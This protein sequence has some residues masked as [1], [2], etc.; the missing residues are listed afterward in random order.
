M[1]PFLTAISLSFVA[2]VTASAGL[3][4]PGSPYVVTGGVVEGQ[5]EN[6]HAKAAGNGDHWLEAPTNAVVPPGVTFENATGAGNLFMQVQPDNGPEAVPFSGAGAGPTIDYFVQFTVPG[7]Y[8][9][10]LRWDGH[11]GS[12]D[13][14]YAGIATDAAATNLLDWFED[15]NHVTSDFGQQGWD[16]S[17]QSQVNVATPA[18]NAMTF[19]ISGSGIYT[20]RVVAREDGVAL[21]SFRIQLASM[22]DPNPVAVT[23]QNVVFGQ[24][25]FDYTNGAIAG[26]T[27]GTYW[28]FDNTT[29][30]NALIGYTHQAPSTWDAVFGTPTITGNAL[31]TQDSAAKREHNASEV[32]G[33][34][35][36]LGS[37][38][39]Q[40]AYYR[41]KMTR[42]A[43]ATWGGLSVYD[44]GAERIFFGVQDAVNPSSGVREFI[45]G[46]SGV[47]YTGVPAVDGQTY[48]IVAKLDFLNDRLSMWI[49]PDLTQPEGPPN[50]IRS[51][52]GDNWMSAVRLGSGGGGATTWD[53]VAVGSSW[54]AMQKAY[55]QNLPASGPNQI[56][57]REEFNYDNGNILN[58]DNGIGWDFD[59][60]NDGGAGFVGRTQ[61]VSNWDNVEGFPY[62]FSKRLA[63]WNSSA[64][65][66]YNATEANGSFSNAATSEYKTLYYR[67]E[68]QRSADN[69]T[70]SGLS[71][72]DGG[73][74]LL[75]FGVPFAL[76]PSSSRRELGIHNLGANQWNYTGTA[77][78]AGTKYQIIAKVDYATGMASLYVN[79]SLTGS[80]PVVPN[81]TIA[82]TNAHSAIRFGSGG[83][84]PTYWD[85]FT[86]ATS[87]SAVISITYPATTPASGSDLVIGT[88]TFTYANGPV[89][90]RNGGAH[91]D[92]QNT[93]G[94]AYTQE[95]SA[96]SHQY[97][98]PYIASGKLRTW[99]SGAVRTFNGVEADG[100]INDAGASAFKAVY[101]RF[102]MQRDAGV[103]WG[104]MSM[105]DFGTERFL[106]GVPFATNPVSG[107]REFAI[108][109]LAS[110]ITY[111]GISP[112]AG[113]NYTLVAKLDF[114]TNKLVLWVNPNLTKPETDPQNTPAA[115]R[116]Y[117]GSNWIT[118]VRLASSA[119]GDTQWENLAVGTSWRSIQSA[120]GPPTA[121][122]DTITMRPN[123][124]VLLDVFR[125][126]AGAGTIQIVT[127][128]A[129]GT[130]SIDSSGR[131][132]YTHT[133]GSPTSDSLTY[134]IIGLDGQISA[135]V[136]VTFNFSNALRIA[137]QTSVVPLTPPAT[138]LAVVDSTPGISFTAP[139]CMAA[140][141]G[142]TNKVLVGQRNGQIWL[143]N[144]IHSAAPTRTLFMTL[145]VYDDGNE[146]G[147]K[148]LA[149]H[150]NFAT[151]RQ[152]FVTYNL[153]I[154][155]ADYAR[156]SRF[157]AVNGNLDL[158]DLASEQPFISIANPSSIH[159]IDSCRFGPDGYFYWAAGDAGNLNDGNNNAQRIDKDFWAGIFRIDVDRRP[160]NIEPNAHASIVLNGSTAYYKVPATNP[161]IGA[162]SFNGLP[163]PGPG[164]VR[165]EIFAIGMRNPWQFSFDPQNGEMW[166]GE[167]GLD[168]WEE[169]NVIT[170]G[171]NF[172]WSYLE[173]A[174]AG[175]KTNPPVGFAPI[176]PLWT[177]YHGGGQLE[178]KSVTGG[179]V[180]R[181]TRYP[182]L[183]GKYILGDFISGHIWSL[184]RNGANP[185]TVERVTGEAG[186]VAFMLDPDPATGD[187]LMLDYG[188][189]KVR[190]LITQTVDT[191]FPAKLSDTGLFADLSDLSLNPGIERYDI[192]LPFWSDYARKSRWFML[193]NN[194]DTF[195]YVQ[196][197][198]WNLPTG[199]LWIKHFD[200]DQTR[201]NPVTAK[202]LET[203]LLVKNAT[204][205]YGVSY[206]WNETGT[207]AY[208]V[209]DG[210]DDFDMNVVINS[211]PTNV[212]WRIP[213]RSEC[214]AC[215]TPA[216][217]H[218]LSFET[219]QLNRTGT[220][221]G[222]TGNY[223][224]LLANA[225]Y[226]SS[227]P[228]Q[229]L[230]L[231]K[232]ATPIDTSHSLETRA[233]SWLA[234]NCSYCHQS[235]GTGVGNF[236]L[237]PEL[238]LTQSGM[239]DALVG[240]VQASDHR[241]VVRG[242][243]D[244]SVIWNRLSASGGYTRMP[245]LATAVVDPEGVQ[246]VM[247]WINSSGGRQNYT[248][249]RLAQFGSSSSPPGDPAADADGDGVSNYSEFLG[250]TSPTNGASVLKP[251]I[252]VSSGNIAIQFPNL[253]G[254]LVKVLT[255]TDLAN[256]STWQIPGND[257]LPLAPSNLTRYFVAPMDGNRRFFKLDVKEQ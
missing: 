209:D 17:G 149:L 200:Y 69:V 137:N 43:G 192:N 180:Y 57:A 63:T 73:T 113:T 203:R 71:L 50:A 35:N 26:K 107:V 171:G 116:T 80:E 132:L 133:T 52:T 184:T 161:F 51:Y 16:G 178:G 76:N 237:R 173:G 197:G 206:R 158:G 78:V 213:S 177:Y 95:P 153:R 37:T 211:T 59:N 122:A 82:F 143:I 191:T 217:G 222:S 70:W 190:R 6:Y 88:D 257:G 179:L 40:T 4:P 208:L 193:P 224:Q 22:Q 105:Y 55:P 163:L 181:G 33:V 147:L 106:F 2:L 15:Y 235:G 130:A 185:P 58:S 144:D 175:P 91:W 128:P 152:F 125:N 182:T 11:D 176:A 140:V 142:S 9:L 145:P 253:Q 24:D 227:P 94:P 215:H 156:V 104:G 72:Y 246:V 68:M 234:V 225:G 44:F 223:L 27:G 232:Y 131:I 77:P 218:G 60:N 187:I 205:S 138:G 221:G 168:S 228:T 239:I 53:D 255:S 100:A 196:D 112:V 159:N 201:G 89:A 93:F 5:A 115:E 97:N 23:G 110:G 244:K 30:N 38:R 31:V 141:P 34:V 124:K 39:Y 99:D 220:L 254:R 67:F 129:Y 210:G 199:A 66:E 207:E 10:Y 65:R 64:K 86:V 241:A 250:L 242:F 157:T 188:D 247:D 219:A 202:R 170:P 160:E 166:A 54:G 108:H 8:R 252:A 49:N 14:I 96:W 47:T 240:N 1:R 12:S 167:V 162:T 136:T 62:V 45:I 28:D 139:S 150:P 230:S 169:V 195:G 3:L 229:F 231:P 75:M 41:V 101:A 19:T 146:L 103:S 148:G 236:D 84:S 233:R 92:F 172:G 212:H 56:I 25:S 183:T 154:T 243:A 111:S 42:A 61:L 134:R 29:N 204:G 214:L 249:W 90:L 186:V 117:T 21:D 194:T 48:T 256:W 109:D 127:S 216:G 248:E 114:V 238:S 121:F 74:E 46:E 87:W 36:P 32:D 18:Q 189:G 79:P 245:P 85:K 83:D 20:L 81:A 164:P 7:T 226:L 251:E 13:S 126:D 155:G 120:F 102:E 151:N 119:D 135:P 174:A 123:K 198:N 165:T 98:S 118:A